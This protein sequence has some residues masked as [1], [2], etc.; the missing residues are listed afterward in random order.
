VWGNELTHSQV[1]SLQNF[2]CLKNNIKSENSLNWKV[3]YT[4]TS[5]LIFKCL[6]CAHMTHLNTYNICYGRKKGQESKCQFDFWLIK[7][8]NRVELC[9]L[10]VACHILLKSYWQGLQLCFKPHFNHIFAQNVM[11]F[12][13]ARNLNFENFRISKLGVWGQNDI[14]V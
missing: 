12:Q 6:K 1:D 7:V 8:G 5:L 14:W 9:V 13:S 11:S 3:F 2:K 10:Q 4:I